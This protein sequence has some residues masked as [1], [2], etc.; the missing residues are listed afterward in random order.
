ML[1]P[2]GGGGDAKF[3]VVRAGSGGFKYRLGEKVPRIKQLA[4]GKG[5]VSLE[6]KIRRLRIPGLQAALRVI[7]QQLRPAVFGVARANGVGVLRGFVGQ[8]GYVR[9]AQ[10]HGFALRAPARGQFVG[11]LGGAGNHGHANQVGIQRIGQ[12]GNAFVMQG[13]GGLQVGR[14]QRRQGGE[15]QWLVAQRL[16]ENAPA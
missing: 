2:P 9:A 16:F 13:D 15:G 10:H 6:R 1:A 4:S 12:G 8:Q 14:H 3:A 7:A 11:A 5:H